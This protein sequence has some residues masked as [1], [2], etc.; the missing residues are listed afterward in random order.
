[1]RI[2]E[3][4]LAQAFSELLHDTKGSEHQ[5]TQNFFGYLRKHR[6]IRKGDKI[7]RA[8]ESYANEKAG[9]LPT[10]IFTAHTLG[11]AERRRIEAKAR[12][13]FPEKQLTFQYKIEP[14]LLGGIRIETENHLYDATLQRSLRKLA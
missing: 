1:M 4:Q 10:A 14:A 11:D 3:R 6:L 7:L 8:I 9:I 2:T 12:S 13:I 5:V